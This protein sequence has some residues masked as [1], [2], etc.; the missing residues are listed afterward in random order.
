ME[1]GISQEELSSRVAIVNQAY[2]SELENGKRNPTATTLAMVAVALDAS[3][4]DL[5]DTTGIPYDW[6]KGP[7]LV[8]STRSQ[9]RK[10]T[11]K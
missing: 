3:V 7:I 9:S 11:S 6:C 1:V 2:I 8:T 10:K 5:F 4:G